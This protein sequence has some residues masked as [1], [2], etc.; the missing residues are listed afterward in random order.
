M[1]LVGTGVYNSGAPDPDRARFVVPYYTDADKPLYVNLRVL[2]DCFWTSIG[3]F[4]F[5]PFKSIAVDV[6]P[7]RFAPR[8]ETF[9]D[10]GQAT[11]S[12]LPKGLV[13]FHLMAAKTLSF[14]GA[15]GYA[16]N[17]LANTVPASTK[18]NSL[19]THIEQQ[20]RQV[21][22][23][24]LADSQWSVVADWSQ[25]DPKEK[26][27]HRFYMLCVLYPSI[28]SPKRGA[29]ILVWDG[30]QDGV[31]ADKIPQPSFLAAYVSAIEVQLRAEVIP[32]RLSKA[33][34]TL[35]KKDTDMHSL[36]TRLS[37]SNEWFSNTVFAFHDSAKEW[38]SR[39]ENLATV[40]FQ[41][42]QALRGNTGHPCN[43]VHASICFTPRLF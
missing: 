31:E 27:A 36:A 1:S 38:Q 35:L 30:A 23:L 17:L 11:V 14:D 12:G 39:A 15:S 5:I 7:Q 8:V 42:H 26:V 10:V 4:V 13:R 6:V 22:M 43:T 18:L 24:A 16:S 19:W 20:M 29:Y 34:Q 40:A 28:L 37:D 9:H 32:V 25:S 41:I 33:L 21:V 2:R 3:S